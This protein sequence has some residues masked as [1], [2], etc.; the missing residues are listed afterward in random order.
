MTIRYLL[1]SPDERDRQ[2]LLTSIFGTF[3]PAPRGKGELVRL[4]EDK[5]GKM[6]IVG[7]GAP[8]RLFATARKLIDS[9]VQ[10]HGILMLLSSGDE[11][12]WEETRKL[13]QWLEDENKPVPLKTWV[14]GD[15]KQIDKETSRKILVE[16][17]DEHEQIL[18]SG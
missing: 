1:L 7:A 11:V 13:T 12:S 18:K 8:S 14:M 5:G 10:I 9:A 3:E 16:L 17:M 6:E 4:K 15:P 2:A